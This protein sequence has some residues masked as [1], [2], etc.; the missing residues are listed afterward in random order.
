MA[1]PMYLMELAQE[2]AARG[3]CRVARAVE[4]GLRGRCSRVC[5]RAVAHRA[6]GQQR[7]AHAGG[8]RRD[9]RGR[10]SEGTRIFAHGVIH[11]VSW[12][13]GGPTVGFWFYFGEACPKQ[14]VPQRGP[15]NLLLCKYCTVISHTL[16]MTLSKKSPARGQKFKLQNLGDIR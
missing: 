6:G 8:A 16:S 2:D 13:L 1:R 10:P 14:V 5:A 9:S 11:N 15:P 4:S 3:S 12:I 7:A